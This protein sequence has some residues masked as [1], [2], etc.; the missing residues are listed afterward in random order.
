VGFQDAAQYID[1][2]IQAGNKE[3]DMMMYP[4]ERHSFEDP[5]AWYDE[6]TRIYEFFEE[7]L[8]PEN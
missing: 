5:D 4:T 7:H 1:E 6:Y 3:F 2:L 8:K